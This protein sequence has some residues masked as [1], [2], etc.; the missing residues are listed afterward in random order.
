MPRKDRTVRDYIRP[1]TEEEGSLRE[2]FRF[3]DTS[4]T[5]ELTHSEFMTFM[6]DFDP[7]MSEEE[8]QIGF[9]EIDTDH[10]GKITFAEFRAWWKQE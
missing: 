2:T 10:D 3:N 9:E 7:E 1:G 5:G 8:C 6:A 4:H